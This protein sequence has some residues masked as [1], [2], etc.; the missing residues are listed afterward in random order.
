MSMPVPIVRALSEFITIGGGVLQFETVA[1]FP[2][3][4]PV[5]VWASAGA[6]TARTRAVAR[7]ILVERAYLMSLPVVG[8]PTDPCRTSRRR[9]PHR[10]RSRV[11]R[12]G[13][14]SRNVQDSWPPPTPPQGEAA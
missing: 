7:Q 5:Q 10:P 8:A 9:P 13:C 1:Q 2:L 6:A 3:V 14:G 12:V 4:A 11:A